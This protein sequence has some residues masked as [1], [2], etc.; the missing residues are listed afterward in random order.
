VFNEFHVHIHADLVTSLQAVHIDNR[1]FAPCA[2]T[3]TFIRSHL[4]CSPSPGSIGFAGESYNDPTEVYDRLKQMS[5]SVVTITIMTPSTPQKSCGATRTSSSA[6]RSPFRCPAAPRY[7]MGVYGITES[8]HLEI[9]RRRN[10][11]IALLMYLTERKLFFQ[12]QSRFLWTNG[13]PR[14]ERLPLA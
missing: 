8:E 10:D 4:E 13:P 7:H 3:F 12:C 2:V 14:G 9:Q 5:M 1:Q 6:R 11:F